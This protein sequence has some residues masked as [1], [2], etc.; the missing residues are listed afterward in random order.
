MCIESSM[1]GIYA[2]II[3]YFKTKQNNVI[4]HLGAQ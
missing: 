1:A 4:T 2:L 3:H